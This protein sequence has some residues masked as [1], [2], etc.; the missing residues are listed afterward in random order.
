MMLGPLNLAT[1][2]ALDT[3]AIWASSLSE[4]VLIVSSSVY[5]RE[6]FRRRLSLTPGIQT[7]SLDKGAAS[8]TIE[9]ETNSFPDFSL[10]WFQP[11]LLNLDIV[12]RYLGHPKLC[13]LVILQARWFGSRLLPEL[14][15]PV[16]SLAGT[17]QLLKNF[18]KNNRW[19]VEKVTIGNLRS[20]LWGFLSGRL[21]TLNRLDLMDLCLSHCRHHLYPTTVNRGVAYISL[22]RAIRVDLGLEYSGNV[23]G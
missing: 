20:A 11:N 14:N 5:L 1:Q 6:S 4:K 10:V 9:N 15:S 17:S 18:R 12:N 21:L 19:T 23:S 22:T 3:C 2:N 16:P 7:C 13:Q 8:Q